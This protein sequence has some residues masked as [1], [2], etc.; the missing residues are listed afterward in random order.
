MHPTFRFVARHSLFI[1]PGIGFLVVAGGLMGTGA[2]LYLWIA[3]GAA[4]AVVWGLPFWLRRKPSTAKT[5]EEVGLLLRSGKI[6]L[7]H[8]YSDF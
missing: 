4:M 3:L 8:F 2:A 6:T 5:T 1:F 7:L